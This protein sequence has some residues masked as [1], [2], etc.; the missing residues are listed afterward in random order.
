MTLFDKVCAH[1][2]TVEK[3]ASRCFDS[4]SVAHVRVRC[5]LPCG[6]GLGSALC[7]RDRQVIADAGNCRGGCLSR[8][9]DGQGIRH[10]ARL[11]QCP[12]I[13]ISDVGGL[14]VTLIG[15]QGELESVRDRS[16]LQLE[17]GQIVERDDVTGVSFQNRLEFLHGRR[18][19]ACGLQV[20]CERNPY[21]GVLGGHA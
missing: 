15:T 21:G 6:F 5:E 11:D 8:R 17:P 20:H 16:P 2:A 12:T 13:R 19:V 7:E 4:G 3:S 9:Q 14:T 10:S 18:G 1:T